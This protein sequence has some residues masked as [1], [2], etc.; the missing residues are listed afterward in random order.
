MR[1]SKSYVVPCLAARIAFLVAY[2]NKVFRPAILVSA[3]A[4][5]QG[6]TLVTAALARAWRNQGLNV[7][8]FKCGPDFIDSMILQAATGRPVYNLDLG[9][10][11]LEDGKAQLFRAAQTADVIVVEGVMGLYDGTPSTADIAKAFGLPVALTIDASGMAQTFAAVA[12]GLYGFE[13]SLK[14]GGVIANKV[15]SAGHTTMLK[16]CLSEHTPWIGALIKNEQLS[17]PERHLGLHLAQEI[18]DIDARIAAAAEML[19]KELPL[20]PTISFDAP[21]TQAL[22]KPLAGKTIAIARDAA[23]CF[24]YPANIDCLENLGANLIYFSP[25]NDQH[26][27]EADAYWLPGGYPELHLEAISQNS[28][29]RSSLQQAANAG[30]A[31][32]AECGGMMALGQTLNGNLTFAV[33]EGSSQIQTKLQGLGTQHL[34]TPDGNIGAHTFHY[35]KFETTTAVSHTANSRYG[36]GEAVYR[37]NKITASFLHFYFPSNPA[38][39]ARFFAS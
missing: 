1:R 15:G 19:D 11:G 23:F 21:N 12:H 10:C 29:M 5:G 39:A 31:I 4:S 14:R 30:K 27:P 16:D 34:Q 24:I 8:A 35:G 32:L 20:P 22:S 33:L 13:P 17:L 6:K 3:P 2:M 38:L 37:Q 9:M 7:Q 25:L 36:Q 28:A 26:L 18:S